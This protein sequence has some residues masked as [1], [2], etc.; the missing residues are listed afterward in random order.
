[1]EE[2]DPIT[3]K[4]KS[5]FSDF[6]Q[7]PPARAWEN[8][9][10]SLHPG[11]LPGGFW[12]RIAAFSLLPD[13]PLGFYFILGGVAF[14]LFLTVIYLGSGGS[15]AIRGHAYAGEARLC[16]G[17]AGLF[18]VNDKTMPW[19]SVEYYRSAVIDNSGHFQFSKVNSGHYLLRIS[20]EQNSETAAKFLPAWFDRHESSDSCQ[21]I[22][23]NRG[24][25]NI[26]AHL[27]KKK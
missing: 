5:A 1:M 11:L 10:K 17:V 15:F 16:R 6:E 2:N 19:D 13:K 23:I 24:D 20:P 8:L 7:E 9:H 25:V 21:L 14:S 4:F 22:T 27:L 3:D 12:S 26:D 18:Q